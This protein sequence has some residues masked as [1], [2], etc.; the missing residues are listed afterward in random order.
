MSISHIVLIVDMVHIGAVR[1]GV[2]LILKKWKNQSKLFS[3]YI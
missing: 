1:S 3:K 2:F